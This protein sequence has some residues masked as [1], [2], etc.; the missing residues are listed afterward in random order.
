MVIGLDTFHDAS[1]QGKSVGAVVSSLNKG[2]TRWYS[3]IYSQAPGIELIEGLEVSI[4]A[5]LQKFKAVSW[6]YL[7]APGI[8]F[9][10]EGGTLSALGVLAKENTCN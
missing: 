6:I 10:L 1:R 9:Y 7:Q 3:K 2:L 5:C 4:L 8:E